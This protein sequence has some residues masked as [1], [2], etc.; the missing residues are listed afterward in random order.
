[1]Q[2]Q[3]TKQLYGGIIMSDWEMYAMLLQFSC[4][5]FKS[6]KE[7]IT[8]S[9]LASKDDTYEDE[10]KTFLNHKVLR[11]AVVYGPNGS[12][13]SNFLN[14]ISFMKGLI[15]NSIN[16]QPGDLIPQFGHKL[17]TEDVP[18][19]F[20]IQF[21][22]KDI[23][24][25]YG[26]SIKNRLVDEEYLYYF[27]KGRQVKIFE[28]K[29][30]DVKPGDKYKASFELSLD[31][32]K[33]NRLFLSCA[34]NYTNIPE[35]EQAFLFFKEDIV[36]YNSE[37]NNWIEYSMKSIQENEG[38][39]KIFLNILNSLGTGIKDINSKFEKT[40]VKVTDL[41]QDMPEVL[42]SIFV[43][44]ANRLNV[45]VIYDK[46]ATDLM[47]EESTGVQKLFEVICPIIDIINNGKILICDEI[48]T[49]L[50]ESIVWEIV[51][52]F[53]K[54]RM[55]KFAQILFT[56]HDTSLLDS[57]LFRRDQIWFTELDSNRATDLYSLAEI[58]NVR[59]TENLRNG[60]MLGKYRAMPMKGQNIYS[61]FND[62]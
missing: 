57:K 4:S 54:A 55:D 44:E 52:L 60:Y 58:K 17:N 53:K 39:K 10:L 32:L 42:K 47:T 41:P 46:F 14:S 23:R 18:T 36:I 15:I 45:E 19:T 27:P 22:K 56:T 13:K 16:N 1:M 49:S 24:Y 20:D 61:L 43:G 25:A 28:R 9:F 51:S 12:G 8:F 26:F 2:I 38:N 11:S 62:D 30:N 6:I 21:V 3:L 37:M 34:A 35:I 33:E 50:H 48:E 40:N 5:N 59:K 31:V 7:K 29:N